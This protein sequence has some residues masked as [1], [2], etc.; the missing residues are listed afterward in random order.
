VLLDS[1]ICKEF[2]LPNGKRLVYSG[3]ADD[4]TLHLTEPS[5][6]KLAMQFF[7]DYF[8]VS[9]V[10]LNLEKCCI[11]PFNLL[12]DLP[13][14]SDCAF[15]WLFNSVDMDKLLGVPVGVKFFDDEIWT[16]L[17]AKLSSSIK[18][19]T[20]QNLSVFG[21]FHAARNYIGSKACFLATMVPPNAEASKS[22]FAML[23]AYVQNDLS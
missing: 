14:P 17:I 1:L 13:K 10:K 15:K 19:W 3:Y 9:R 6:L 20:A 12:M 16:E 21:R 4:T 22:F 2:F 7:E 11:I 18:H 5:K 23:W 8:K